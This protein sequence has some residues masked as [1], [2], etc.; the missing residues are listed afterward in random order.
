VLENK[1]H[2]NRK[3]PGSKYAHRHLKTAVGEVLE[4]INVVDSGVSVGG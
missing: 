3:Q 2:S 1:G 4:E